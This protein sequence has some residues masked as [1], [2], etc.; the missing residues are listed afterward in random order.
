MHTFLMAALNW[1]E[2]LH[3]VPSVAWR[4]VVL[5]FIVLAVMRWSGKRTVTAMAPFDLALVIMISEVASIP[6][7]EP[8]MDI[9]NGLVPVIMI[10]ALHVLLTTLNLY[11][12]RMERMTEGQPTLLVKKG[13][14][15]TKNLRR[16]R[17]SLSDLNAA[18][19]LQQV[20]NLS[21]VD[22]AW[23]EPTGGVSVLLAKPDQP[24][25]PSAF[26][27]EGLSQVDRIVAAHV[28]RLRSELQDWLRTQGARPALQEAGE[29][30]WPPPPLP[31]SQTPGQVGQAGQPTSPLQLPQAFGGLSATEAGLPAD[32]GKN[33]SAAS[34]GAGQGGQG[35]GGAGGGGTASGADL[36]G[37]GSGQ[38]GGP[39]G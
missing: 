11:S 1:K 27:S 12:V 4:T 25:T 7:S 29:E 34:G 24:L 30:L 14:V 39:G 9:F 37:Q 31:P 33:Y 28:T 35:S 2:M 15:L 13:K 19:R 16:E 23:L 5:F 3:D 22:E 36:K 38:T 32:N 26:G 20:S 21:Q 18:L 6:I 10:G 17:V 8:K